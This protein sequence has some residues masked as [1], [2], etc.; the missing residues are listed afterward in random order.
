[1]VNNGFDE[2]SDLDLVPVVRDDAYAQVTT[3]EALSL[4]TLGPA[5]RLYR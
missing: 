3:P 2:L 1:M 5:F 4:S